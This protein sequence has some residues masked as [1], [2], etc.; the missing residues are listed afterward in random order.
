MG[1]TALEEDYRATSMVGRAH[2]DIAVAYHHD[3]RQDIG[4]I[5]DVQHSD[6]LHRLVDSLAVGLAAGNVFVGN[7]SSPLDARKYVLQEGIDVTAGRAGEKAQ[8]RVRFL[9]RQQKLFVYDAAIPGVE[10]SLDLGAVCRIGPVNS[11]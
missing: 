11:G 6:I 10:F 3:S 4:R 1:P 9:E 7:N 8:L 5:G 2:V